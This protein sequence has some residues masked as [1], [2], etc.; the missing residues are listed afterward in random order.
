MSLSG[1]VILLGL[2]AVACSAP[3]GTSSGSGASPP[4]STATPTPAAGATTAGDAVAIVLALDPHFT[5]LGARDPGLVGQGSWYEVTPGAAGWHVSVQVGWGDC[6]AGCINRHTWVYAVAP[7]GT[8]SKLSESGDPLPAAPDSSASQS[9][10]QPATAKPAA[11]GN[12]GSSRP[13]APTGRAV[14]TGTP[15]PTG[16]PA[17]SGGGS[18]VPP[19]AIPSSGGPWLIGVVTAGPTCPVERNPP[20]P[21]CAARPVVAA[22]IIVRGAGGQELARTLTAAD[23]RYRVAVAAGGV[24]VEGAPVAGLLRAPV[25]VAAVVPAGQAAW[26]RVDLAYDTGIR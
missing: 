16:T 21:A 15:P 22:T 24:E 5:G 9:A 6:P 12:P 3:L 19:V 7:D 18:A 25:P 4:S 2:L 26:L 11:T 8:P 10:S 20:D 13:P 17:A 14:P 1:R 23:G